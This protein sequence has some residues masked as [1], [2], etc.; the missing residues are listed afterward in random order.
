L[1]EAGW[2]ENRVIDTR[3]FQKKYEE[4]GLEYPKSVD[5]FLSE[6]G[7]LD[8]NPKDKRYFDVSFDA[9]E[10]IGCNLDGGFFADCL[11]EY[12]IDDSVYPV[13]EACRKN[14][15]VLM[16]EKETFYCYTNGLL[17]LLGESVDE[18][19]DCIV[20]ECREPVEI[21]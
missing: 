14:L 17:L 9:V 20:G 3:L 13:G 18:M 15:L 10:A 8:I 5:G 16:T 11:D 6:F 7:M 4:I 12:D 21:D 1:I 2:S 19:L